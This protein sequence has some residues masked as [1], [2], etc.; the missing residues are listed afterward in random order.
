MTIREEQKN[1]FT[2]PHGY[3][4]AHCISADFALG[5]GIALQFDQIYNMRAK[6]RSIYPYGGNVGSAIVIDNV[7]NL[8]TKQNARDLPLYSDLRKSLQT[9]R[10]VAEANMITKIAMPRIGSGLDRLEWSR[11]K[12]II[13]EVFNGMDIDIVI[14]YL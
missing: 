13:E 9:M 8:I 10:A 1:L 14:C 12:D 6:L 5:A 3:Y 7:F 2:M 4:F 11:V